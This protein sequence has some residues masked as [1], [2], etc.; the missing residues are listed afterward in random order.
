MAD[1]FPLIVNAVS[2]KIEEIVAGDNLDLTDNGIVIGGDT[3]EG[4]YITSDGT[5]LSWESIG[6]ENVSNNFSTTLTPSSNI[7]T[8]DL[9][10]SSTIVG[11]PV[12]TP[13]D[14]WN[15]TNV[16]LSNGKS[17]RVTVILSANTT[18]TYGDACVVDGTVI[19]NGVKWPGGSPPVSTSNTDV[20]TFLIVCDDSGIVRVFGYATTNFA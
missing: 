17:R 9:S 6:T 15:F 12:T 11:I 10:T 4:K 13:I 5:T 1:R 16:G 19:T 2:Q 18:A 8:I 14:K 20:L 3:G 7:L